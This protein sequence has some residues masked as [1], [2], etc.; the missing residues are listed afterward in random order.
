MSTKNKG[1]VIA[2]LSATAS[3]LASP[4]MA[5]A[6][7]GYITFLEVRDTDGLIYFGLSGTATGKPACAIWSQW[8]IPNENSDTGKKLF[9]MLMSARAAGQQVSVNGKNT[10][11]RWA[12]QEDVGS[13]RLTD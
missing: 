2:M 8:S 7:A 1:P 11:T 12:D 6:Q 5:G 3:L 9:A 10:C 4:A 13:I